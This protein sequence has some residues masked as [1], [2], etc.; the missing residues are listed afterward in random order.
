MKRAAEAMG[1][2]KASETFNLPR[3]TLKDYV[4]SNGRNTVEALIG[5]KPALPTEVEEFV[6]YCL[7]MEHKYYGLCAKDVKRVAYTVAIRNGVR[8]PSLFKREKK[9]SEAKMYISYFPF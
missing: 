7:V 1:F 6:R 9:D 2:L 4:K 3:S 5:R 8:H